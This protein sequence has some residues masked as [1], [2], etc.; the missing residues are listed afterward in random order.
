MKKINLCPHTILS[1]QVH[2]SAGDAHTF[3]MPT[4]PP[5]V[6]IP[7]SWNTY[8]RQNNFFKCTDSLFFERSWW[9]GKSMTQMI[10]TDVNPKWQFKNV[11][12]F[13]YKGWLFKKIMN[14]AYSL[15]SVCHSEAKIEILCLGV[16]LQRAKG[17]S[18]IPRFAFNCPCPHSVLPTPRGLDHE[19]S[20]PLGL[21]MF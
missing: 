10:S 4:C 15:I 3:S 8:R 19:A 21:P 6:P 18:Q 16:T 12:T 9:N 14:L 17:R 1:F 7:C 11:T 5:S 13:A 20:G 2:H